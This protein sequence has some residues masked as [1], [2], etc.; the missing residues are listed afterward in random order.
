MWCS[1]YDRVILAGLGLLALTGLGVLLW[2][3]HTPPLV[4]TAAPT[5]GAAWDRRLAAARQVDVNTADVAEL[6]RLPWV[7]PSLAQRIVEERTVHGRFASPAD[8]VRVRGIG[9][10][11]IE[12]LK[13]RVRMSETE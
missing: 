2:Q 10:K 11:T 4:V 9:P 13:D 3:R 12:G 1:N 5:E 7:G 6:E 8:L